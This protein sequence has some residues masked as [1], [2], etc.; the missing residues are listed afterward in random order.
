MTQIIKN[1]L[2]KMYYR[3]KVLGCC[4]VLIIIVILTM[5]SF[6][7]QRGEAGIARS[8]RYIKSLKIQEASSKSIDEKNK[9]KTEINSIEKSMQ[10]YSELQN[11]STHW[12][13]DLVKITKQLQNQNINNLSDIEKEQINETIARNEYLIK[14]SIKPMNGFSKTQLVFFSDYS[15]ILNILIFIIVVFMI[16]D[17]VSDEYSS[18]T[19]RFLL[20]RPIS[21]IQ[22]ILGKFFTGILSITVIVTIFDIIVYLAS[23]IA[24]GFS[25]L[26]FPIIIGPKFVSSN[27]L[28]STLHKFISLIPNSS[29]IIPFYSF[30]LQ[31]W[32]LQILFIIVSASFC[33]FISSL[34]RNNIAS[35]IIP[36]IVYFL[37]VFIIFE[38][39]SFNNIAPILSGFFMNL[40]NFPSIIN[41]DF[42][43]N[44]GAV[45]INTISSIIIMILWSILFII[46]SMLST[47]KKDD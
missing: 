3:K 22:L 10:Q 6:N 18:K 7:S 44:T 9:I 19:I 32:I 28:N 15:N 21:K 16:S 11:N 45:Y 37:N 34:L 35:M 24:F 30:L 39:S 4:I 43:K 25:S 31:H 40:Y 14:N 27:M 29:T 41:R 23:G 20:T 42:I 33:I 12:K 46:L 38:F 36:I 17:S 2:I 47:L 8:K 1:E 26:K 5:I 13:T